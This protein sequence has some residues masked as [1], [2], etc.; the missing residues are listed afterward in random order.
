[1]ST[2]MIVFLILGAIATVIFVAGYIRGVRT[3]IMTYDD[4]RIETDTSGDIENYWWKIGFAVLAA[5][6]VIFMVGVSHEFVYVGPFLAIM[7]AALNG[8][9]FFLEKQPV[10]DA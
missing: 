7:T 10:K 2:I 4:D 3:A 5:S 9:A 1:M 8:V 6:T